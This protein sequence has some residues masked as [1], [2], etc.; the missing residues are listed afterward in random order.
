MFCIIQ[1][2]VLEGKLKDDEI[3][4]VVVLKSNHTSSSRIEE[5]VESRGGVSLYL[6]YLATYCVDKLHNFIFVSQCA[7]D[8]KY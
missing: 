5:I 7:M 8:I 3:V 1:V 2:L 6:L 4:T